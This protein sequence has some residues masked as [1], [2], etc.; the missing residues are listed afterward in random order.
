MYSSTLTTFD[1]PDTP[2][3]S[4][5]TE[6]SIRPPFG[7]VEVNFYDTPLRQPQVDPQRQERADYEQTVAEQID[8][9]PLHRSSTGARA[10]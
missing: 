3:A 1:T 5:D 2:R 4:L 6:F 8:S 9:H 10:R 7:D